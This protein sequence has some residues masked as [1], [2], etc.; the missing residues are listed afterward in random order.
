MMR[1]VTFR[2]AAVWILAVGLV[3]GP[4]RALVTLNDGTDKIY[5]SG[6][7]S[8]G[9]DSNIN[10]S[11]AATAD[12]TTSATMQ[13]EYQRRAGLIGV[14]ADV[15]F[16]VNRFVK[17][18]TY[19]TLNPTYSLELDKGT[20]RTTGTLNLS[21]TRSSQTDASVNLY[22]TDWNYSASLNVHYPVIDRYSLAG[23]FSYGYLD[24]TE[25]GGQPL[26]DLSTYSSS[27]SLFYILSDERDLF[28][29]YRY[30]YEQSSSD[31]STIDNALS[32]GV[33]GKVFWEINGSLSAGYQVREPEGIASTTAAPETSDS[34]FTANASVSWNA[35]RRLSFTASLSKDFETTATDATTDTTAS[36]LDVNYAY[37][38]SL[39]AAAGVGAGENDFLGVGGLIAGTDEDRRDYYFTSNASVNYTFTER[40]HV[41]LAYVFFRNWSNLGFASFTRDTLTLSLSSRW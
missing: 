17:N 12:T 25:K 16:A 38:A 36:T 7:F 26:D 20:G 40:L 15:S 29:T 11:A 41:S 35:N 19:D 33:H 14:N 21:A 37:N 5:V 1:P 39:S 28:A 30:R 23:T 31:T 22:T 3:A 27:L 34:A 6:T 2:A 24:Y 32:L 8:M 18:T 13:L 9:Y 4:A 10:A